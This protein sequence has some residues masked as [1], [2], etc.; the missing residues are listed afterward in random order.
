MNKV[1]PIDEQV[2]TS[3]EE[4]KREK[5]IKST[6][7]ADEAEHLQNKIWDKLFDGIDFQDEDLSPE[8]SSKS[9]SGKISLVVSDE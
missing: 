6:Q 4:Y 3:L 1:S 7:I 2:V 5:G 9:R 8:E